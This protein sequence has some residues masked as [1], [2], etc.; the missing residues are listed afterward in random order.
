MESA[1]RHVSILEKLNFSDI[2]ISLKATSVPL[3]IAAYR[4]ISEKVRYPLH[5]GIT[6]AGTV[7]SGTIKS[8]SG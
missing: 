3:T 5:V 4:L 8:R 7:Y 6:E 1:L 2:V